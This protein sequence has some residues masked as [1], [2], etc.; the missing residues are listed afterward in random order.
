MK[1]TISYIP[2]ETREADLI[3]CF[4]KKLF[5]RAKARKS[6]SHPPQVCVY[7]TANSPEKPCGAKKGA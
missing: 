4:I 5:P 6:T 2:P 7:L 1:I 3:L